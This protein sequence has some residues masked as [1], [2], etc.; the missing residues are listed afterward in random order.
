MPHLT[1]CFREQPEGNI[2]IHDFG[3]W[4]VYLTLRAIYSSFWLR[5]GR[6]KDLPDMRAMVPAILGYS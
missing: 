4:R 6:T 3:M 5:L 2:L 1:W